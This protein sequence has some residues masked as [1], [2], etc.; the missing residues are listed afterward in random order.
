MNDV[1]RERL[2][3]DREAFFRWAEA[4][5]RGRFERVAGEV[6]QMSPERRQ[7]AR[8]KV[9]IWRALD[10]ALPA[11]LPAEALPD[12]MTVAV[13][14][15]TDFEPDAAVHVGPPIPPDALVVPNPVIVAEVL[16]PST[17]RIDTTVKR[18]GYFKVASIEHYLVFRAD[19]REVTHY[20]RDLPPQV[21]RGGPLRLD[22]PGFALDLD[23]IYGRAGTGPG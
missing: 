10:A 20:R 8:V 5:P 18:E 7:H 14:A 1:S 13:D 15:D 4:Q 23:A 6:V 9:E 17:R 19:R 2:V 11:D 3:L 22:P 21:L 12:G 16:S